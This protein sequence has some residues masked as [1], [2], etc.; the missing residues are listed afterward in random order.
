MLTSSPRKSTEQW[1]VPSCRR[2]GARCTR[3][4]GLVRIRVWAHAHDMRLALLSLAFRVVYNCGRP[5]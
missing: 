4:Y 1:C 5:C 2:S 3:V